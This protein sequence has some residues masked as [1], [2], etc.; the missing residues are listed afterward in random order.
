MSELFT[1]AFFAY[2]LLPLFWLFVAS[3]KSLS[4]LFSSF[5]LWFAGDVNLFQDIRDLL[6]VRTLDGG[7]YL[8]WIRSSVAASRCSGS[9]SAR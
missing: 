4:D 2:F 7:T 6:A 9:C 8:V 5:G 1:L 3:T